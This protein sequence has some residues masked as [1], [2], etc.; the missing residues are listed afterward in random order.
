MATGWLH[1]KMVYPQ[2]VTYRST[3]IDDRV[4]NNLD[5]VTNN[6]IT[7]PDQHGSVLYAGGL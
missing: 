4:S 6:I 1:T 5:D 7:R 2:M 3:G